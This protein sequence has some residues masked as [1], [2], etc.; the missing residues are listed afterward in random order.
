V[1][2]ARLVTTAAPRSGPAEPRPPDLVDRH[3]SAERPNQL[4]VVDFTY[5]STWSH[6]A[7]TAFVD[8]VFSRRIVGWRGAAADAHRAAP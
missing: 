7:F 5:V 4:W 3:F 1:S 2:R 6:M 8:D